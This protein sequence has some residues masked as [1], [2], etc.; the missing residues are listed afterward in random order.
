MLFGRFT[1]ESKLK[2]V[3]YPGFQDYLNAY[4][5]LSEKAQPDHSDASRMSVYQRQKTY[6]QYSAIKDPAVGLFE[7]YFGKEWSRSFVHDFLFTLSEAPADASS[8]A[9]V[10]SYKVD[11][12]TGSV[13]RTSPPS[14]T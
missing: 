7:A 6:D 3:V 14:S 9:P 2:S 12:V 11:S 13:S 4:I 5:A 10:H 1:D 8:A